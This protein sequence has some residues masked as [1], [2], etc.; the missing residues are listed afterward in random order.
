M[1][2]AKIFRD[3]QNPLRPLYHRFNPNCLEKGDPRHVEGGWISGISPSKLS[4]RNA[5]A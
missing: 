3:L 2:E 4:R 1:W 5:K